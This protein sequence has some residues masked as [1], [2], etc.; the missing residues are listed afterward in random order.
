MYNEGFSQINKIHNSAA[1]GK[2]NII[3][4]ATHEQNISRFQSKCQPRAISLAEQCSR[5]VVPQAS[6]HIKYV[7]KE[8]PLV[9]SCF[10]RVL[11]VRHCF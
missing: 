11:P 4:S 9:Q 6:V 10:G 7:L 2:K 3:T 1:V 5:D 8:K